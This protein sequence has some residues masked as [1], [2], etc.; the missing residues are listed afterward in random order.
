MKRKLQDVLCC[1]S[2][3]SLKSA[4]KVFI[5]FVLLTGS[6]NAF[7]QTEVTVKGVVKDSIGGLPGA[8]VKVSGTNRGTSTDGDG[9]YTIKLPRSGRLLFTA[10][11]F[12]P[13]TLA[14]ADYTPN[15]QGVYII[16]ALLDSDVGAL[17][18]VAI[19]GFGTQ[20][21]ASMIS[22]ITTI[23]PKELKGPTSNLTTMMQG[24]VAGMIAYQRTGEPGADNAQFFIRGLGTFGTGKQDPLILIDGA[25]STQNDM[26][27]LQ[28][29]D[30]ASFSVLK[31]ASA[32]A[33][34]GARG[35]NGVVLITT[36]SGEAGVTKFTIRS[37]TAASSNT[38][39]FQFADNITYMRMANEAALTRNPQAALPY[40]Q[41]KIDATARGDNPLLYPSNNW[42]EQLVKDYTINTRNNLSVEGG[43]ENARYYVSGTYNVDNGVLKVDGLSNFNNNVKLKNYNVRSNVDLNLTK[44]TFASIRVFGQFDDYTGPLL[45]GID[46]NGNPIGGGQ[47]VFNQAV[48]SN[49]VLFPA[50]YP[51]S[52][53]PF[54]THTLFGSAI[55]PN[56]GLYQNPYAEMV[57]GYSEY[58]S[59]TLQTQLELK[60]D[61]G[62]LVKGLNA[63]L[64]AYAR[65]YSYFDVS[66]S[67]NPF[68]Y[69]GVEQPD[70]STGVQ[71][72]NP[73]G[74]GSIGA[75]GTEYLGYTEGQK[76]LNS[77]FYAEFALNYNRTFGDKHA[78][79]GMLITTQRN[80]LSGNAGSLQLSL[81][82]R[83]QGL[84]GRATY[85]YDN[86]YLLELNFG[87][88]G[89]ERFADNN[90]FGFF[91]TI[92]LGYVVSNEGFFKPLTKVINSLKLRATYGLAGNDQIGASGDRF[93]YMSEVNMNDGNYGATFGE[94]WG[95]NK[96]GV[97]V[98]RYANPLITW[99]ESKQLN[100]GLDIRFLDALDINIDVYKNTRSNILTGRTFIP[101]T[102]GLQAAVNANTNKAQNE[103]VDFA[104]VYNKSFGSGW[105]AQLR[106]N[107][108]YAKSKIL[109]ND[110]PSFPTSEYY[111]TRVGHPTT[112]GFGLIAER[113]FVDDNEAKNAPPQFDGTPGLTYGGGDIKYRDVN[114][115]GLINDQDIVPIGLPTAPEIIYGFGGTIGYKDFDFSF[116]FQ[117]SARSS[118]FIN[119]E[120]I[121]P[122][123]LNGGSQ[124]GLLSAIS[125]SYWSE[126]N[127]D[128]YALWPRLSPNF[129][130]NN[131]RNS[132]WWMRNGNFLRL[133]SVEL[134]YNASQSV[135]KKIGFRGLRVYLSATN[136]GF[137]S[138][139]KT[140]DPEMG[141]NGLGYPIQGTYN[142]GVRATF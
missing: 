27:R 78:V 127:R 119:S 69:L 112:Q 25:E 76:R 47:R 26:A 123:V 61:L 73:G 54:A 95:Y 34:Y 63:R 118:F 115:D 90:R 108:T 79:S 135:N 12:K 88:N 16:N 81:P 129:V 142:L 9:S 110:E 41:T 18:E 96:A 120:N 49:P 19:V 21:K 1:S 11:G 84:S 30:I 52:L 99:E 36:K 53:S 116:F 132:T 38:K 14:V 130:P 10:I 101:A 133:R 23:N 80:Y 137:I 5:Y 65:R 50:V 77:T 60:Q 139:F 141:G 97:L 62:K 67:Y 103:G 109:I 121:A 114:G 13:K 74:Q 6:I 98:S 87:Y 39:N 40:L 70:G 56:N 111:R 105:S 94:L 45:G 83:N 3:G 8:G 17:D 91:P 46:G 20:K 140:W 24:R 82:A 42:I 113:L 136:L 89:S 22:S 33:V 51:S 106:G 15:A 124:N 2:M 35:A 107:F 48:W 31:D 71:V 4:F 134:G 92:G 131:N 117:G 128:V 59:S 29:D 85:G 122:F 7:A 66:R 93:F 32:S 68:Y 125:E 102:M 43:G 57:R 37:E 44:T 75:T 58:N 72:L 104:A 55:T 28:P 86:K 126:E 100:L 138:S 64:M